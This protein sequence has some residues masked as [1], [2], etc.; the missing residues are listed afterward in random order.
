VLIIVIAL[1]CVLA[2]INNNTEFL[3]L[4]LAS[5]IWPPKKFGGDPESM[6]NSQTKP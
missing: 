2:P 6:M 5:N 3:G 1:P 4:S